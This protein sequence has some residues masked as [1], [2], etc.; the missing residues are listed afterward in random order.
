MSQDNI[1]SELDEP[2]TGDLDI[3]NE[4]YEADM[5]TGAKIEEIM[6]EIQSKKYLPLSADNFEKT[7]CIKQ[8]DWDQIPVTT[9]RGFKKKVLDRTKQVSSNRS[10][11]NAKYYDRLLHVIMV[12]ERERPLREQF[13]FVRKDIDSLVDCVVSMTRRMDKFQGYVENRSKDYERAVNDLLEYWLRE[14]GWSAISE[15][16]SRG[17]IQKDQKQL[18]QW[19]GFYSATKDGRKH[20]FLVETK[21][22]CDPEFFLTSKKSLYIKLKRTLE[23]M[24]S[25]KTIDDDACSSQD[26]SLKRLLGC[27]ITVLY[28]CH[29]MEE[30][31]KVE[32]T[33]FADRVK[34]EGMAENVM[35]AEVPRSSYGEFA[36]D[37]ATMKISL[38][39]AQ[40]CEM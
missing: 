20:I 5:T 7:V 14:Q 25:L 16:L 26:A 27:T 21:E 12:K 17:V 6:K 40:V 33:S 10:N 2:A 29:H 3:Y 11:E 31:E 1:A 35:Y 9:L 28:A 22:S 13:P 15:V 4:A 24:D 39:G 32:L 38:C 36:L 19:D 18:V 30:G 23:Y 8:V 37:E 34:E